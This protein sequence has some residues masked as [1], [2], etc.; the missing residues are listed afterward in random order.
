MFVSEVPLGVV[1]DHLDVLAGDDE[2]VV[3]VLV[4]NHHTPAR[5]LLVST[6]HPH[7][8]PTWL[9]PRFGLQEQHQY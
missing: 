1:L 2:S 8:S 6:H 7:I 5:P 4:V 3:E 9:E